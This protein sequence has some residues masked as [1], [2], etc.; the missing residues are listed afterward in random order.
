MKQTH[1]DILV[2]KPFGVALNFLIYHSS[3]PHSTP[4]RQVPIPTMADHQYSFAGAHW[5][6]ADPTQDGPCHGYEYP[7]AGYEHERHETIDRDR[8][9]G[10]WPG[11]SSHGRRRDER[12]DAMAR[13]IEDGDEMI[14]YDRNRRPRLGANDAAC[15]S[16]ATLRGWPSDEVERPRSD[17]FALP[18]DERRR[19]DRGRSQDYF[20]PEGHRVL[21]RSQERRLDSPTA[22]TLIHHLR[23][24]DSLRA[25]IE[26]TYSLSPARLHQSAA[27]A[28]GMVSAYIAIEA[29]IT[30]VKGTVISC[31]HTSAL[32]A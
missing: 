10:G 20:D 12:L 7:F 27:V 30:T 18:R 23:D 14:C 32:P 3:Q 16:T 31:W 4:L 21:S 15:W 5:D 24:Q 2:P 1:K 13:G 11:Y 6:T 28:T 29:L 22:R 17:P 19:R 26:M 8:G 9:A 25:A